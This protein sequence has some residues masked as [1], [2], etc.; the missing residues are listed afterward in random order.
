ME[1]MNE[2]QKTPVK[3]RKEKKEWLT[4]WLTVESQISSAL[5]IESSNNN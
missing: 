5:R 3:W 1:V 4:D 2:W